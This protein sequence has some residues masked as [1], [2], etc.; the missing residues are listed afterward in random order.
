MLDEVVDAVVSV[1][2]LGNH[3]SSQFSHLIPV[4]SEIFWQRG[5][6]A[7]RRNQEDFHTPLSQ[8]QQRQGTFPRSKLDLVLSKQVLS[9][10]NNFFSMLSSR[11][12][13]LDPFEFLG[14]C[15]GVPE[16]LLDLE[17]GRVVFGD[18]HNAS[19]VN[20]TLSALTGNRSGIIELG[21]QNFTDI[22]SRVLLGV[23][24]IVNSVPDGALLDELSGGVDIQEEA[25][26]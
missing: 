3:V 22:L 15:I 25:I 14:V 20:I 23:E 8:V 2:G 7:K 24:H 1:A 26:S 4:L 9:D 21:A 10:S 17:G 13:S 11:A 16:N 12:V 18:H 6:V 5:L 19:C